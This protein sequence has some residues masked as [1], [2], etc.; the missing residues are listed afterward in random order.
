MTPISTASVPTS[1]IVPFLLQTSAAAHHDGGTGLYTP[2]R[3][4]FK[5]FADV[6]HPILTE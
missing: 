2:V 4:S 5:F 3:E 1:A 6:S